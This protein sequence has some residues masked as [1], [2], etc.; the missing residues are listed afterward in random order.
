M[1]SVA[2][3][4]VRS[5]MIDEKMANAGV[6]PLR[7]GVDFNDLSGN[8][9][10]TQRTDERNPVASFPDQTYGERDEYSEAY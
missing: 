1:A 5:V 7:D 10:L 3:R 4:I 8:C 6:K 2:M 9:P